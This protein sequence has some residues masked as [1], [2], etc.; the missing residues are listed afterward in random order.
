L[1]EVRGIQRARIVR[2]REE[3][4]SKIE[5]RRDRSALPEQRPE[6]TAK[7]PLSESVTHRWSIGG[8]RRGSMAD[9]ACRREASKPKSSPRNEDIP[10]SGTDKDR[11]KKVRGAPSNPQRP[12]MP[13]EPAKSVATTAIAEGEDAKVAGFTTGYSAP[14]RE[15]AAQSSK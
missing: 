12:P 3:A 14:V 8:G 1:F 5:E 9:N 11:E 4:K 2:W 13:S 10:I 7:A 15:P 6:L